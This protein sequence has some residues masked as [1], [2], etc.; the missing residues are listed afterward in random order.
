MSSGSPADSGTDSLVCRFIPYD[1]PL[2]KRVR[3]LYKSLRDTI[4]GRIDLWFWGNVHYGALY[5]PWT[6]VNRLQRQLDQAFNKTSG[7]P[8]TATAQ[9]APC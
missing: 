1:K 8:E 4:A 9:T 3:R 7:T 6:F 2:E 5:E